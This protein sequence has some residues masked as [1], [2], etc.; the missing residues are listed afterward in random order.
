MLEMYIAH[1][2]K[3]LNLNSNINMQNLAQEDENER[4]QTFNALFS[5]LRSYNQ[6]YKCFS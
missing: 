1:K 4:T 6:H 5:N 3:V 2:Q